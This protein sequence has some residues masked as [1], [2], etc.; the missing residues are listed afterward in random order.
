MI[1]PATYLINKLNNIQ[2]KVVIPVLNI[3]NKAGK[4]QKQRFWFPS[5]ISSISN[6]DDDSSLSFMETNKINLK[7]D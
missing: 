3:K 6:S 5:K 7:S 4:N 2:H 1:I